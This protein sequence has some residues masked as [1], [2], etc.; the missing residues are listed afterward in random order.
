MPQ[1]IDDEVDEVEVNDVLVQPTL[2]LDET[3]A[4]EQ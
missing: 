3:D 1:D 4:N 2:I